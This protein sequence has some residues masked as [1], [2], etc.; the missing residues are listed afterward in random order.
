MTGRSP[1]SA[2][3]YAYAL[4]KPNRLTDMPIAREDQFLVS[5]DLARTPSLGLESANLEACLAEV[6][7]RGFKAVFGSPVFGF[8]E[9][10]LDSLK[11]LPELEAIWFWDVDLRDIDAIYE[12]S[13]LQRFGIHDKRPP[14]DF[15]RLP[16]LKRVVWKHKA[17][18]V[19]IRSLSGL[20]LL[21]VWSYAP[22]SKSFADLELPSGLTE[23]QINWANPKTLDGMISVPG[24]RRLEIARC[25]NL[26]TLDAIPALFPDLEHLVVT[27]CGRIQSGEGER[28]V[29]RLP[30]LRHAFVK[31]KVLT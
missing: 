20:E 15:S 6:R 14:V 23:L 30:N 12:H 9:D 3:G 19:G 31:D 27:A 29:A 13:S 17:S 21:H 24:L 4:P 22:R 8:F 16:S 10:S 18:D 25:R 5:R 7:Q 28:V 1:E 2:L 26:E 11:G